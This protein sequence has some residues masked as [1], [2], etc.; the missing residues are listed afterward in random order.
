M[1]TVVGE[2]VVDIVRAPRIPPSEHPGGSPAN[3]AVGLA[4][5]D[6]DTE[7]I[8]RFG[9]DPR[10]DMLHEH[11]TGNGVR[12]APGC[13]DS[14]TTSTAVAT[15]DEDGAAS[16]EFHITW[17]LPELRLDPATRCL[18]TGSLGTAV[19]PG[20]ERVTEL[21]DAVGENVLVS[22]DPNCRPSVDAELGIA[23]D[24]RREQV[25]STVARAHVVKVSEDDLAWLYPDLD[26]IAAAERWLRLGPSLVLVTLGGAGS[27][28]LSRGRVL[29]REAVS[30]P[31]VD[32]VGA[33]DAYTAG[34][35]S[36]FVGLG[37]LEPGRA[38]PAD[39]AELDDSALVWLLDTANLAAALACTRR[40]A[41]PPT[42]DEL[43]AALGRGRS[44]KP[45]QADSLFG[46]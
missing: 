32:T 44:A 21:L 25:E 1:F 10:G 34:V 17:D 40:G 28:A 33:G 39:I 12:L 6:C 45:S 37:V 22:Y 9:T 26:A 19:P 36:A 14:A 24:V 3:V 15:L 23:V 31:V 30:L 41:D 42:R 5:L 18:H 8:A 20:A 13:R 16:Y 11:L 46:Q 7:L 43:S 29:R 38:H 2:A 4:R 27:C 35:L